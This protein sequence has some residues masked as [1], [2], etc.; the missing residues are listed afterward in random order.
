[1]G[2][3]A[4]CRCRIGTVES[5]TKV[6]LESTEIIIRGELRRTIP[7]RSISDMR[8]DGPQLI[9]RVG[10]D[11][12]ALELGAATAEKW[13][14]AMK[15]PPATLAQKLGIKPD[16]RLRVLGKI[17][18]SE[19]SEALSV[20]RSVRNGQADL[21][22]AVVDSISSVHSAI[23]ASL[24][25]LRSGTALWFVYPKGKSAAIGETSVRD[26]ARRSGLRDTKVASVSSELTALRFSMAR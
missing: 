20:G 6:L 8:L 2:R 17:D 22:I 4:Q 14:A 16:T 21:V 24:P 10:N 13:L 9:L 12:I 1:M 11:R 25:L 5:N 15:K 23:R 7:I 18:C 3:E 26:A 19:L